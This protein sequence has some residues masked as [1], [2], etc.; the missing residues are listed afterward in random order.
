MGTV[1][2][3]TPW[4]KGLNDLFLRTRNF[5]NWF[6]DPAQRSL[7]IKNTLPEEEVI[8]LLTAEKSL[9]GAVNLKKF[10]KVCCLYIAAS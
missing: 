9:T 2:F 5:L 8:R 3:G 4:S 6:R 7:I 1:L 10:S